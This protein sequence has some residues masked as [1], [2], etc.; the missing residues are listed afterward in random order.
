MHGEDIT[1]SLVWRKIGWFFVTMV[2][3]G[4]VLNEVWKMVQMSAYTET[5]VN[6]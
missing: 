5:A 2:L 6:S 4:F 1:S 3:T